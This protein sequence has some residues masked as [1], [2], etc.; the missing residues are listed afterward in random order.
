[1]P[2][3]SEI[4]AISKN[5]DQKNARK[6]FGL[7]PDT[8]T[9]LVTG[10]SLG[11]KK[12]ND[13]VEKSRDLLQAAGVQVMHIVGGKSDLEPLKQK[14]YLRIKYCDRM[15]L[16]I[17]SADFAVSRAGSSTV[18]ELTAVGIPALYLPYSVGNGEQ[19]HNLKGLV[20]SG[21]GVTISDSDFDR[22]YVARELVPLLSSSKRLAQ[23]SKAAKSFG[24]LD[25]TERLYRLVAGVLS[26]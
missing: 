20:S 24:I 3:R 15:D 6:H 14:G 12:I 23:M 16:A 22:E 26:R 17:A 13:T 21:G 4:E 1:M 2:L 19:A 7:E 8:F 25:G 9:L 10:G 5:R 18:S 11:A